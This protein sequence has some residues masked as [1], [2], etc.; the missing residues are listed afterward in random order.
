GPVKHEELNRYYKEASI[1]V[2]P[3][4]YESFGLVALEAMASARP[5]IGFEDTGLSE[6]V[7]KNAGILV[8]RSARNLGQAIDYLIDKQELCYTLGLN[9]RR[10]AIGFKWGSISR[11]Y[12][13]TYEGIVKS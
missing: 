2:V 4:Y 12:L 13:K 6:T 5:V 11:E 3:S 7:G 8:K 10:K 1:L 9:G